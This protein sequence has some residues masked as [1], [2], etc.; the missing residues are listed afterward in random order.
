MAVAAREQARKA[1]AE[2]MRKVLEKEKKITT[3]LSAFYRATTRLETARQKA[4]A[5]EQAQAKTVQALAALVDDHAEVAELCQLELTEV[6]RLLRVTVPQET[7]TAAEEASAVE[8]S[9]TPESPEETDA[10]QEPTEEE[11]PSDGFSR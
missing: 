3:A 6:R 8:T 5:A 9:P 1:Q 4:T 7:P 11:K 10:E 2:R